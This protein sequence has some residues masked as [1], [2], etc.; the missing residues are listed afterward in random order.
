MAYLS[1]SMKDGMLTLQEC[2]KVN[3]D[4]NLTLEDL[5]KAFLNTKSNEGINQS[6][7]QSGDAQG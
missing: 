3:S 6:G 1:R 2:L 7:E 5:E 4:T